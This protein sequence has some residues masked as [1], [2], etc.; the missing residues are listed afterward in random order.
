M[1]G[2]ELHEKVDLAI[3][4]LNDFIAEV[5]E[6]VGQLNAGCG[7]CLP[8][9]ARGP[10]DEMLKKA[11]QDQIDKTDFG[12]V[13]DAA[14]YIAGLKAPLSCTNAATLDAKS[15]FGVHRARGTSHHCF[16][17]PHA[18][19]PCSASPA[20]LTHLNCVQIGLNTIQAAQA[21]QKVLPLLAITFCP[22]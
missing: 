19:H 15:H 3:T 20:A 16:H 1:G 11:L 7:S 5:N 21:A 9:A 12:S 14:E 17:S 4:T 18:L 6:A 8:P 10:M 13:Q 2:N 22:C